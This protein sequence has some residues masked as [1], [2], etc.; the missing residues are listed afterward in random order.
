MV[1]LRNSK[2]LFI[3]LEPRAP[4]MERQAKASKK[5]PVKYVKKVRLTLRANRRQV[6]ILNRECSGQICDLPYSLA[7]WRLDWKVTR[8]K[9]QLGGW[10]LWSYGEVTVFQ[11]AH[12]WR[13]VW[14]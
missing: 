13:T 2:R 6:K 5:G 4:N 1:D 11:V 3:G 14:I 7:M 8:S 10:R 12:K 9:S